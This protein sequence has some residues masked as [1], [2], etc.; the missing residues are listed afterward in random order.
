MGKMLLI[1]FAL[2]AAKCIYFRKLI[3]QEIV[4]SNLCYISMWMHV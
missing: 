1:V 4:G 2:V 3:L